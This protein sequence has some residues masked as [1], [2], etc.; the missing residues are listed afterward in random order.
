[1]GSSLAEKGY[2][3]VEHNGTARGITP[4]IPD[5]DGDEDRNDGILKSQNSVESQ[6]SVQQDITVLGHKRPPQEDTSVR[7]GGHK[8]PPRRTEASTECSSREVCDSSRESSRGAR[9]GARTTTDDAPCGG[10]ASGEDGREREGAD[11]APQGLPDDPAA[12]EES[13]S[14]AAIAD[15]EWE[16]VIRR[17]F[18][19]AMERQH[20][21]ASIDW[22]RRQPCGKAVAALRNR[23]ILDLPNIR[24]LCR[25]RAEKESDPESRPMSAVFI[26][27]C[28]DEFMD[29]EWEVGTMAM[30]LGK[31]RKAETVLAALKEYGVVLAAAHL[32]DAGY[33]EKDIARLISE[34]LEDEMERTRQEH[35]RRKG[36]W[37]G[38][39]VLWQIH[40]ATCRHYPD[41]VAESTGVMADWR[42][43]YAGYW[44]DWDEKSSGNRPDELAKAAVEEFLG[45]PVGDYEADSGPPP[46]PEPP[47][48]ADEEPA[49]P[50]ETA[51]Y[52]DCACL[53]P[54]GGR[55]PA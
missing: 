43:R 32:R 29:M 2:A 52:W 14:A 41:A 6:N 48:E 54:E 10:R 37:I 45:R 16:E 44:E 20:P 24:L 35:E 11:Q 39:P 34:E 17:E 13:P 25:L 46:E 50:D 1:M 12:A 22:Y 26:L 4:A 3:I 33:P 15:Q 9:A 51:D 5:K 38:S 19:C 8:R 31:G 42:E 47:A 21:G 27:D 53:F 36:R 7:L 49:E 40:S 18:R 30:Q 55:N 28:L 23:G